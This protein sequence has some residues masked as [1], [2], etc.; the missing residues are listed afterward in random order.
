MSPADPEERISTRRKW[1]AIGIGTLLLTGSFWAVLT[2]FRAWLGDVTTEELDAGTQVPITTAVAVWLA[3]GFLLMVAGFTALA[4][5]SRRARTFRAVSVATLLGGVMWLWMPFVVGE[6]VTPMIAGFGAG[7]LV[8]LRAEPE[9][10]IGRRVMAAVLV[11]IYVF[12]MLRITPLAAAI[13]GP[14]LPLPALA[15][16]DALGERRAASMPVGQE[17]LGSRWRGR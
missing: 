4:L 13:A 17:R 3:G 10:T 14:L 12:V 2:G 11:T 15:W 6:P 5:I 8:A 7:G 9:H 16:A 1:A